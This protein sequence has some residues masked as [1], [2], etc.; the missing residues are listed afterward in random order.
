MFES[1]KKYKVTLIIFVLIIGS[2]YAYVTFGPPDIPEGLLTSQSASVDG[3]AAGQE[4]I[5]ILNDIKS[6]NL[7]TG[8]FEDEKFKSLI[9]LTEDVTNEPQGRRNPFEPIGFGIDIEGKIAEPS[10]LI[11]EIGIEN[12]IDEE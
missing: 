8:I 2:Y 5:S 7:D 9:D 12:N 6:I 1:I 10:I 11:G 3:T 4:I